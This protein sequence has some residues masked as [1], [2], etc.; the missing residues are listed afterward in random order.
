MLRYLCLV[1]LACSFGNLIADEKKASQ[2]ALDYKMKA[3]DGQEVNLK[4]YQGKVVLIVN[5]A[6][7]CGLTPQ[8]EGLQSLY[9]KYQDKGLV[10]L[11]VPCNQFGKQEPGTSK[12]IAEFCTSKYNVTFDML[13]KVNVNGDA[14][15]PLYK[16]L[17]ALDLQPKGSG[18]V[19]WNFEKFLIDRSG[20][21]VARFKPQTSPD[22]AQL[23]ASI[24][25]LLDVK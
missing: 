10:V 1:G 9:E 5:V 25:K 6:S 17:T 20:K 19:S 21:A 24:E 14:A 15:S 23:V 16:H 3:L 12:Q 13:E 8:Y 22:D 18:Q 2:T 11:G 4:D 7:Q